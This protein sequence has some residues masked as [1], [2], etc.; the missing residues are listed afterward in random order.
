MRFGYH[1]HDFEFGESLNGVKVFDLIMKNTDIDKVVLQLDMGNMFIAGA[2]AKDVLGQYPGRYDNIHVKDMIK[3]D[4]GHESTILGKGVIG[5]KE[6]TDLAR[7]M[8]TQLFVVE[9]ESYQGKTPLECMAE[10][11]AIMK[12][13]GY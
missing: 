4:T 9:Q 8:G 11:L 6:V 10:D 3:T 2:L 1:N 13:W 5:C 7:D 12:E